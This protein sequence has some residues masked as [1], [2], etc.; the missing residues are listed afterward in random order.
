MIKIVKYVF[1]YQ[2]LKLFT[3]TQIKLNKKNKLRNKIRKTLRSKLD[4]QANAAYEGFVDFLLFIFQFVTFHSLRNSVTQNE[5][6]TIIITDE[7]DRDFRFRR[8]RWRS[9]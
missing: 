9:T 2:N 3:S 7:K 4:L 1:S 8:R 6:V 5:N